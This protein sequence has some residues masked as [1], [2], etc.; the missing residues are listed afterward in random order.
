VHE[1]QT[2]ELHEVTDL[3]GLILIPAMP[4]LAQ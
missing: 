4:E 1:T 3:Y 2:G